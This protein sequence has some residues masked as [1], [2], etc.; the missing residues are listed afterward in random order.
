MNISIISL[1]TLS[2]RWVLSLKIHRYVTNIKS[3]ILAVTEKRINGS[4]AVSVMH[5]ANSITIRVHWSQLPKTH[6]TQLHDL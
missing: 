6:R 4:R 1:K 2:Q 3:Q 5:F